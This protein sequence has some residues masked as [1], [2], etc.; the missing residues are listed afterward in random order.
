[1]LHNYS[2]FTIHIHIIHI[3]SN[4]PFRQDA[5]LKE[6]TNLIK[7]VEP[8]ARP[9]NVS[10]H[11]KLVY[12]D[13]HKKSSSSNSS[14]SS[15]LMKDIGSVRNRAAA[16]ESATVEALTLK[17]IRFIQGDFLDVAILTGDAAVAAAAVTASSSAPSSSS[18]LGSNDHHV[19]RRGAMASDRYDKDDLIRDPSEIIV[20]K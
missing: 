12:L 3:H 20:S 6:L 2:L 7:E 11:F 9:S 19:K 5:T 1:M 4:P 10:F 18:A 15:Y 17:D 14:P 8:N 16:G 13:S